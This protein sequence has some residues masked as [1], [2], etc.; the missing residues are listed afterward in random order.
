MHPWPAQQSP[1]RLHAASGVRAGGGRGS[2][3]GFQ[4]A[5]GQPLWRGRCRAV[6]TVGSYAMCEAFRR[7]PVGRVWRRGQRGNLAS[8]VP[9]HQGHPSENQGCR[10]PFCGG[11]NVRACPAGADRRGGRRERGRVHRGRTDVRPRGAGIARRRENCDR[12]RPLR[13]GTDVRPCPAGARCRGDSRDR[14]GALRRGGGVCPRTAVADRSGTLCGGAGVRPRPAG[15]TC[16]D[17]S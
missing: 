1:R 6:R 10:R 14:R 16:R 15:T 7:M 13:G 5:R 4:G 11:T 9:R 2:A 8:G 12:R 3:P 17:D